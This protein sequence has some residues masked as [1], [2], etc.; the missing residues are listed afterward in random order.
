MKRRRQ[1]VMAAI[2]VVAVGFVGMVWL[3]Q[4]AD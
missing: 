4:I 2:V 1:L 3:G